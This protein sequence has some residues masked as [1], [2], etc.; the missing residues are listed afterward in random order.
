MRCTYSILRIQPVL[1]SKDVYNLAAVI[2]SLETG[3]LF[4]VGVYPTHRHS[5]KEVFRCL[6]RSVPFTLA[7]LFEA[8]QAKRPGERLQWIVGELRWN[9]HF[10]ELRQGN[11]GGPIRTAC[12][13][14]FYDF[15]D[16]SQKSSVVG[17]HAMR[18]FEGFELGNPIALV[19]AGAIGSH[20]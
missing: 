18:E 13:K 8:A 7:G 9:L 4:A 20:Q 2:E 1:G 11:L 5:V 14:L 17:C 10:G 3:E 6:E 15:V 12:F 16:S 19:A